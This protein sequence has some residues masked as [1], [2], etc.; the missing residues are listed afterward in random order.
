MSKMSKAERERNSKS[1][2]LP[3]TVYVIG[4]KNGI[5]YKT[6]NTKMGKHQLVL[7]ALRNTE[8]EYKS[9]IFETESNQI[10]DLVI[11]SSDSPKLIENIYDKKLYVEWKENEIMKCGGLDL[12]LCG[13]KMAEVADALAYL[14][15]EV[16][17]YDTSGL[18]EDCTLQLAGKVGMVS[19]PF[20]VHDHECIVIG[21]DDKTDRIILRKMILQLLNTNMEYILEMMFTA[22]KKTPDASIYFDT[23]GRQLVY[24]CTSEDIMQHETI[25]A[26]IA[27][28]PLVEN[29]E[30]YNGYKIGLDKLKGVN[31]VLSHNSYLIGGEYWKYLDK[32]YF[33]ARTNDD[34]G[35]R[36]T[37]CL[38][39]DVC[40]TRVGLRTFFHERD[41]MITAAFI[42]YKIHVVGNHVELECETE[43]IYELALEP[44]AV[45][46]MDAKTVKRCSVEIAK[47]YNTFA[48]EHANK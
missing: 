41:G 7:W 47:F 11:G 2:F 10:T 5:V 40:G 38:G 35:R 14:I 43:P 15:V 39:H 27:I 42:P 45:G 44:V 20:P 19:P 16:T 36:Y 33:G 32:S 3:H 23:L 37:Y 30:L 21:N 29:T 17:K 13:E 6:I 46:F 1:F 34:F 24:G 8:P 25:K 9:V 22:A 48:K 18:R 26:L 4:K 28:E 12:G 31:I